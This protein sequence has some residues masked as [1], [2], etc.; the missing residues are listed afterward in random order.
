MKAR[1]TGSWRR[2][3]AR[4][5]TGPKLVGSMVTECCRNLSFTES[6]RGLAAVS[7]NGGGVEGVLLF[8]VCSKTTHCSDEIIY[9]VNN[10]WPWIEFPAWAQTLSRSCSCSRSRS[11]TLTFVLSLSHSYSLTLTFALTRPPPT[12][13]KSNLCV[14]VVS[15][16][17]NFLV[18]ATK[19]SAEFLKWHN[20]VIDYV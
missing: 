6:F 5:G 14:P 13:P 17:P 2:P 18:L 9:R 1:T 7:R 20:D 11:L 3:R 8:W 19:A 15:K 10:S 4:P 16:R 12:S